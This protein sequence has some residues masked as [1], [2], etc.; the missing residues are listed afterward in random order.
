MLTV[1]ETHL[2]MYHLSILD[3]K[4]RDECADGVDYM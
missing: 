1:R 4:D 3:T 2:V